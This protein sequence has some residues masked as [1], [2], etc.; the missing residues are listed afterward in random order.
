[1]ELYNIIKNMIKSQDDTLFSMK[2]DVVLKFLILFK[3]HFIKFLNNICWYST[4][5]D[6]LEAI[7]IEK[8]E[9]QNKKIM[10]LL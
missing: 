6:F 5:E 2:T 7:E 8:E 4:Y 3:L 1:M 9:C 10:T